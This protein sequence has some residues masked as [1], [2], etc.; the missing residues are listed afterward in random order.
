MVLFFYVCLWGELENRDVRDIKW[1][2]L[3][4]FDSLSDVYY[5]EG[6]YENDKENKKDQVDYTIYN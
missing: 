3:D 6:N 5:E 4:F 2:Q 1:C